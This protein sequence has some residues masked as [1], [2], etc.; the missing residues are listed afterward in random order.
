MGIRNN[1]KEAFA[2]AMKTLLVTRELSNIRIQDLCRI[3]GAER[4]TFYYHFRDKYD[5]IAWIYQQ[6]LLQSIRMAGG[7]YSPA[8]LENLLLLMQ[9]DAVFYRKSLADSTQNALLSYIQQLNSRLA[10]SAFLGNR[11][12]DSLS[13]EEEFYINTFTFSWGHCLREWIEGK[14]D[15]SAAQYARLMYR[16]I[17]YLNIGNVPIEELSMAADFDFT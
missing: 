15:F 11:A 14:Y 3:C 8:Q 7:F 10:R 9:K 2:N 6:D 5:L 13:P 12:C 16:S 4:P 17:P 1:T